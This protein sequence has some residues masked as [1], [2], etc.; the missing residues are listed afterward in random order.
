MKT[1]RGAE[2]LLHL[3]LNSNPE[4]RSRLHTLASSTHTDS[5]R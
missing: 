3:V 2:L 4:V 5:L 1:Y